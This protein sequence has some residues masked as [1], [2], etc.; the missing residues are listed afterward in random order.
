MVK[1]IEEDQKI[2]L[3]HIV[4]IT[5]QIQLVYVI[6]VVWIIKTKKQ[7][8][9]AQTEPIDKSKTKEKTKSTTGLLIN[10]ITFSPPF[11]TNQKKQQK[12]YR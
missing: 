10:F 9:L 6:L 8:I 12:T 1:S 5:T 3:E 11:T 7:K 2:R 4:Q